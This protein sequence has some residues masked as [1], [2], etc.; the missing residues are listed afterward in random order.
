MHPGLLAHERGVKAR[1]TARTISVAGHDAVELLGEKAECHL[2]F[3][4]IL[5]GGG[6]AKKIYRYQPLQHDDREVV[7]LLNVSKTR[8]NVKNNEIS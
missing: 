3:C 1:S 5:N 4:Q 2:L 6:V 8:I 7:G